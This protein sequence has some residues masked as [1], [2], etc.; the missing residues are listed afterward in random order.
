MMPNFEVLGSLVR[1][2]H[3]TL[4]GLFYAALPVAILLSVIIGYFKS[5]TPDYPDVI[6]RAFVAALLL[7]SFPEISNLILDVCDG[8]AYKIDDLG[9]LDAFM[10]MAQEKSRGYAENKATLLIKFDDLII[11]VLSFA[12]FAFV[13]VARYLTISLYYFYWTILSVLS[14]ILILL[15]IFPSTA[16]IT[17]NLYKGLIEVASWK[18]IW[19][20]QSAML[21]TLS[22]GNIY[23]TDGS[24]MTVMI[25]NFV[26]GIGLVCTPLIVR[27]LINEGV[28]GSAQ[29]IGTGAVASMLGAAP[30]MA[31]ALDMQRQ[32]RMNTRTWWADSRLNPTRNNF[33]RR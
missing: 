31:R 9:G 24:Y 8:L 15:Y 21:T 30:R 19:A 18:I 26:I 11:A 5:G 2:I 1:D 10:R 4:T 28:Q 17:R 22:L 7:A 20:I 6:K 25:L 27:S 14:P 23:R 13:Y 33:P 3:H 29:V 16:S 32:V 12:T